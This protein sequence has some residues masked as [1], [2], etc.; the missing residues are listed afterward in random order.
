MSVN[1]ATQSGTVEFLPGVADMEALRVPIEGVGHS[2]PAAG[3]L[4]PHFRP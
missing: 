3:I 2:F 1:L 4:F